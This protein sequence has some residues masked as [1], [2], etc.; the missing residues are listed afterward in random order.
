MTSRSYEQYCPIAVAL[1]AIGDRWTLL[2]LR[3]LTI[4]EQRFTDLR[5]ALPGIAPNLL[6]DRLRGL[7]D[8]GLV[9]QRELPPPAARTVYAVTREGREVVPVLRALARFGA[10]KL[11]PP[12]RTGLALSPKRAVFSMLAPFHSPEPAGERFHARLHVDGE[13][14]DAVTDGSDLSFRRRQ[15]DQPD[16]DVELTARQLIGARQGKHLRLPD[17]AASERFGRLF[18]LH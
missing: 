6:A 4:G 16:V 3:E 12:P 7:Q 13:V 9:E 15:H 10:D 1:D 2:I 17:D 5:A 8:D 14:F 11:G 18:Q